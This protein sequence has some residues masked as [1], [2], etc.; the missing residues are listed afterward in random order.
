M[1]EVSISGHQKQNKGWRNKMKIV[2]WLSGILLTGAIFF[3]CASKAGPVASTEGKQPAEVAIPVT[4]ES[5]EV[6]WER[7]LKEARKEGRVSVVGGSAAIAT[8]EASM[9]IMRDK[10][11]IQLEVLSGRGAELSAKINAEARY[12]LFLRDI[13]LSG[14]DSLI[15]LIEPV[16]GLRNLD[17]VLILPEV[18]NP[19]NWLGG[20]IHWGD[21]EH[22][23]LM[24]AAWPTYDIAI[25]T[26][27]V[28]PGEITSY[29]DLLNPK[30]KDKITINDPMAFG[31]GFTTFR[32]T[33]G[34]KVVTPDYY[35]ALAKEQKVVVVTDQILQDRWLTMGKYPIAIAA[36]SGRMGDAIKAGAP[37]AFV[38]PKEGTRL[39]EGGS[40]VAL[41]GTAPHPNASKVFI[42]W[43]LSKE[44]QYLNQ[45][46]HYFKQSRR[47][48][49][50]SDNIDPVSVR[51]TDVKYLPDI[52]NL[53][54]FVT[55][56]E[57]ERYRKLAQ[58]IFRQ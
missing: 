57:N 36:S 56:E 5:W 18:K 53:R 47:I 46:A 7:T 9:D 42:N 31:G 8:R 3:S 26:K 29:F 55:G 6:E 41:L 40:A 15:T 25:N 16:T 23:Y 48:D 13:W 33:L 38:N 34:N 35:R 50:P 45:G 12:G 54:E 24:W 14:P 58:E 10:F 39:S 17:N 32:N 30:W 11:G 52:T 49:I 2:I 37:I 21:K 1:E 20:K 19:N 4:K 43:F 27:M 22:T 51:R 44:G 28:S